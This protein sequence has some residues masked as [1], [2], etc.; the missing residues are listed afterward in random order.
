MINK[1]FQDLAKY[2][3]ANVRNCMYPVGS[4]IFTTTSENPSATYGG[5]WVS[6]GAGR[7]PVGVNAS[8]NN[9]STVEK[10]GGEAA[11]TLTIE[12]LARHTHAITSRIDSN[13]NDIGSAFQ[14]SNYWGDPSGNSFYTL[15]TSGVTSGA[16]QR[17][18]AL[19]TGSSQAHNNLQP[20]ITCYMWK[21][22]ED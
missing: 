15:A 1:T 13:G 7:V 17:V 3:L 5:T 22:T 8:D 14:I 18:G 19:Y 2:I 4:I 10:T 6:W 16:S 11:H 9:F 21:K 20:Y 12:E